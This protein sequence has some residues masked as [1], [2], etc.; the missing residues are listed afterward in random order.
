[1][2]PFDT[3]ALP[4]IEPSNL[5]I[6]SRAAWRRSLDVDSSGYVVRYDYHNGGVSHNFAVTGVYAAGWWSFT[7]PSS[8]TLHTGSYQWEL[9]VI[10][11]SDNERAVI[12]TGFAEVLASADDK[13]SHARVM[14]QKIES[15]LAGR[16][17]S[18]VASYTIKNRQITKLSV[19]ELM[20][21][22]DYYRAE[23]AR[24]DAASGATRPGKLKVRFI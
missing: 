23:V 14:V 16:A 21:W 22:R 6:G 5:L 3:S 12:Q 18:D 24:E 19:Q 2:N 11:S 10:R 8:Q 7:I 20:N 17:D 1:M 13:R 15:I 9:A 4:T